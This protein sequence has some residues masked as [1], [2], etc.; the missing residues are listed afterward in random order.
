MIGYGMKEEEVPATEK[1]KVSIGGG[2][3][4]VT[5]FVRFVCLRTQHL[6]PRH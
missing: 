4:G 6:H 2:G 3:I 5:S 1:I